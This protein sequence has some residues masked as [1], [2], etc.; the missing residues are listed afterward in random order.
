MR[1]AP[2]LGTALPRKE[3]PP[4]K[5]DVPSEGTASDQEVWMEEVTS[6]L[7]EEE[8]S[9]PAGMSTVEEAGIHLADGKAS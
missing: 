3:A 4:A 6:S 1:K 8:A 7:V 9:R 5:K 2:P